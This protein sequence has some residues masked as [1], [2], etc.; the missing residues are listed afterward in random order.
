M[1][2]YDGIILT[3]NHILKDREISGCMKLFLT[4]SMILIIVNINNINFVLYI[5]MI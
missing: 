2:A 4:L 1:N 3:F 5:V